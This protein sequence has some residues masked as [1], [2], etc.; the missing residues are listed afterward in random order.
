VCLITGH[1]L[2]L[3]DSQ[4]TGGK[5]AGILVFESGEKEARY[6][7]WSGIDTITLDH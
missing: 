1:V 3:T 2:D 6:I 5:H 4:D 7:P